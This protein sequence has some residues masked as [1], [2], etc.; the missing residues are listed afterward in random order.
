MNNAITLDDVLKAWKDVEPDFKYRDKAV[1]KNGIRFIFP[2]GIFYEIN[3]EQ[4]YS[5]RKVFSM[6]VE[7][8]LKAI[9]LTVEYLKQNE[10]EEEVEE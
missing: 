7:Q 10:D 2:N 5:N 6:N 8:S 3:I 4:V 9:N 1:D